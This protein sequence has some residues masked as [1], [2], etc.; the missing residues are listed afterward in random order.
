[1]KYLILNTFINI[2][3]NISEKWLFNRCEK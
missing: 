3:I 1:M 2:F